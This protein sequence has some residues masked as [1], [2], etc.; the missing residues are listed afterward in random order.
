MEKGMYIRLNEFRC[1]IILVFKVWTTRK[2][3]AKKKLSNN[4]RSIRQTG[5]GPYDI[6][7]FTPAEEMVIDACGFEATVSGIP[8]VGSYGVNEIESELNID[9][10][11][12]YPADLEQFGCEDE[13]RIDVVSQQDNSQN[14]T[15]PVI[16]SR[17]GDSQLQML[18]R[19]VHFTEQFVNAYK[20]MM[21]QTKVF[22]TDMMST[23]LEQQKQLKSIKHELC[24]FNA[25]KKKENVL[26]AERNKLLE[27]KLKMMENEKKQNFDLTQRQLELQKINI[28]VLQ[29]ANELKRLKIGAETA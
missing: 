22:Q 2:Y 17:R 21:E 19:Q 26:I 5:G 1:L 7:Q 28:E 18:K 20:E 27:R 6:Q 23:S 29:T 13:I 14:P 11:N 9:N 25:N 24:D 4:K 16:P 12:E 8:N 15:S 10:E 3:K